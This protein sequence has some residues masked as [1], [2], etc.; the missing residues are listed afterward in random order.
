MFRTKREATQSSRLIRNCMDFAA[1]GS[2]LQFLPAAQP[3][4]S[5]IG[6]FSGKLYLEKY[7]SILE[8]LANK[9]GPRLCDLVC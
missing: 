8:R 5:H 1:N 2:D 7:N 9:G 3:P 4:G 6:I